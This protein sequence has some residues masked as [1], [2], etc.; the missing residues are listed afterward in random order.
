MRQQLGQQY[1]CA[2]SP[3]APP[4]RIV[5][6]ASDSGVASAARVLA[7]IP[8]AE[9]TSIVRVGGPSDRRRSVWAL[10]PIWDR[11][12]AT[13]PASDAPGSMVSVDLPQGRGQTC[14]RLRIQLAPRD[15]VNPEMQAWAEQAV[16]RYGTDRVVIRYGLSVETAAG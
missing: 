11:L 1:L 16:Q 13:Q 8:G 10:V 12:E 14:P 9:K 4:E 5:I 15:R 3:P 2:T 6:V 7:A